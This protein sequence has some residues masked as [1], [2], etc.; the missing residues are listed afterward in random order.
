MAV[1]LK[2]GKVLLEV[3]AV[4][5]EPLKFRRKVENKMRSDPVTH[6][7]DALFSVTGKQQRDQAV[8]EAN[9][10][11][12]RRTANQRDA[13]SVAVEGSMPQGST[14]D[15]HESRESAK[16]AGVNAGHNRRYVNMG[17]FVCG[18]HG[19]KQRDCPQS[20]QGTAGKRVHGKTHGRTPVQQQHSLSC[21]AQ[22]TRST[23]TG[24]SPATANFRVVRTRPPATPEPSKRNDDDYMYIRVPRERMARVDYWLTETVQHQVSQSAGLQN[25]APVLDAVP[26]QLPAPASHQ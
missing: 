24:M 6:D 16:A 8:F 26:V 13:K 7:T 2:H 25:A 15:G 19:H 1:Q 23:T 4:G 11:V 21:P 10:A 3:I 20:Q 22:H 5:T 18:K 12:R 14:A 17:C 9:D